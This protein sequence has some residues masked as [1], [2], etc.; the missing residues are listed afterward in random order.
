MALMRAM[1][2]SETRANFGRALD[3]VVEDRVELVISRKAGDVVLVARDEYD[4]LVETVHLLSSPAN[5]AALV[6]AQQQVA[7]GKTVRRGL[8]R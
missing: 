3:E 6:V 4:S 2:V 1:T 5:V 7:E 8:I